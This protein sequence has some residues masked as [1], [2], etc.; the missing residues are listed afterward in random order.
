MHGD[1]DVQRRNRVHVSQ[2]ARDECVDDSVISL[3]TRIDIARTEP[4]LLN[5]HGAGLSIN[6]TNV[7]R[8]PSV[9]L[10]W[11]YDMKRRISRRMIFDMIMSSRFRLHA[12]FGR[13]HDRFMITEKKAAEFK[14]KLMHGCSAMHAYTYTSGP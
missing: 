10:V 9:E 2:C 14:I 7:C 8:P 4:A 6:E 5:T 12:L 3:P 1:M 13:Y 11:W